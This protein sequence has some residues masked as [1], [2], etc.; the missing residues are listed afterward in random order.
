ML[1]VLDSIED[2]VSFVYLAP[3]NMLGAILT[4]ARVE[5]GESSSPAPTPK[6]RR[7]S[8]DILNEDE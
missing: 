6:M 7:L 1:L 8:P 5:A 3:Y 2:D 4:G